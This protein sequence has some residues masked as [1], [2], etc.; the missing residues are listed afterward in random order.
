MSE[1][2]ELIMCFVGGL[3]IGILSMAVV[4]YVVY[5]DE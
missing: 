4:W 3:I 2:G 1:T 5:I